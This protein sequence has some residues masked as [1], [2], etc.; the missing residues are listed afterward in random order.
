[1]YLDLGGT[2]SPEKPV[3]LI[4]EE[5]G[6]RRRTRRVPTSGTENAALDELPSITLIDE[7]SAR[8]THDPRLLGADLFGESTATRKSGP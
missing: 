8:R 6:V 4:A 3:E 1:M 2:R 7:V 5:L